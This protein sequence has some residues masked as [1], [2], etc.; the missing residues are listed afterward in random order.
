MKRAL[1]LILMLCLMLPLASTS[2]SGFG[3]FSMSFFG[4]FDTVISIIGYASSQDVFAAET[5]KAQERF[6]Y[7]HQLYDKYNAYGDLHNLHYLNAEAAKAPVAVAPE[8]FSLISWA[9][10]MYAATNKRVNIAFGSVLA[11]WHQAR[12]DY[13]LDPEKAYLPAMADLREAALHTSLEDLVLDEDAGTI[14]FRDPLLQLDIGAVAK[15]YAAELVARELLAGPLTSFAINAGG[16]IRLGR[17]PLDGRANWGVAVQDPDGFVLSDSNTDVMDTL[18]LHDTSVVTSG[19]Y[20]R[21]Y[22]YNGERYHHIISP[23]TLMP[24]RYFRSVTI[25]TEDSGYADL[26]STALFLMPC[27][28]GQ[29][30]LSGLTGVDAVWVLN[31]RSIQMTQGLK[32]RAKSQGASNPVAP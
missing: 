17:P 12:E 23:D 26:L 15:G 11:L 6:E 31:D 8:L 22:V 32:S 1:C 30:F 29:R 13:E 9:K 7:L 16:N 20:Q 18:F 5:G 25:I 4:S 14:F 2:E 10:K 24:P 3:R 19:D 27:E 28:E 21:Y